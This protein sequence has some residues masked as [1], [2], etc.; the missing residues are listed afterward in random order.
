MINKF[1]VAVLIGLLTLTNPQALAQTSNV[2]VK[3]KAAPMAG[4][5]YVFDASESICGYLSVDSTNNPILAQIKTAVSVKNPDIGN[6][7]YLLKQAS[8]ATA[9]ARRDIVDA[10]ANLQ[11]VSEQIKSATVKKGSGCAP[12]NGVASNIELIF[13]PNSPTQDADAILLITDAQLV[14]KDRDKFVSGF[15]AWMRDAIANGPAF[16]GIALVEAE[17]KGRYFPIS[18]PNPKHV[19]GGYLMGSHNRP[20]LLIW[21]AKSAKHL[22]QIREAVN[23]FAPPSLEKSKDAFTQHILPAFSL[24]Q[25]A[26]QEKPDFNPPLSALILSKPNYEFQKFD[27]SREDIILRSCLHHSVTQ[28]RVTIEA[29]VRCRDGRPIFDGLTAITVTLPVAPSKLL[30]SPA[31]LPGLAAPAGM[32]FKLTSKSFGEQPF[33]LQHSL[34][35]GTSHKID[36]KPYSVDF[37]SCTD[38]TGASAKTGTEE[39]D[40]ACVKK[41]AAKTYQLDVLLAQLFERQER[42]TAQLLAPLNSTKY[43]FELKQR[44]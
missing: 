2:K 11:A 8:K 24:G 4:L 34:A 39:I 15:A 1:I 17:F 16:A 14:E 43:V 3:A 37:D 36:A 31:K 26:F 27:K 6:R 21:L 12:F 41:L 25:A 10:P 35:R 20:L 23:S 29:D 18:D 32:L 28:S 19:Q 30:T 5:H 7:I 9:D 44:K 13:S 38:A 40:E 33:E 22:A 42:A